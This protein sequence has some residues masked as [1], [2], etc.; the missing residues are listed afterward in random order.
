MRM[1]IQIATVNP[2]SDREGRLL[3]ETVPPAGGRGSNEGS[4]S[5]DSLNFTHRMTHQVEISPSATEQIEFHKIRELL[6]GYTRG[7]HGRQYCLAI[8]P[9]TDLELIQN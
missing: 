5:R 1:G 4:G 7:V 8:H 2:D 3:R 6:A 9:T